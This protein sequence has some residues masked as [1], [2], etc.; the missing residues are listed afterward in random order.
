MCRQ[1][2]SI[3]PLGMGDSMGSCKVVAV[4]F[5]GGAFASMCMELDVVRIKVFIVL[6]ERRGLNFALHFCNADLD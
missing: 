5:I 4:A 2:N 3:F 1:E 6:Q